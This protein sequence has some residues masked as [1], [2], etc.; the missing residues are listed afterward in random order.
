LDA[1]ISWQMTALQS[2]SSSQADES[3][4]MLLARMC[5]PMR[6]E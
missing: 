3:K 5:A 4:E 6:R 1:G 2:N